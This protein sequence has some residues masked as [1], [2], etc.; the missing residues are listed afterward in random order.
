M[1]TRE[2]INPL[3]SALMRL[4]LKYSTQFSVPHYKKDIEILQC[5]QR[6]AMKL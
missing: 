2:V 5:V 4:H 3:Y 1:K 6:R